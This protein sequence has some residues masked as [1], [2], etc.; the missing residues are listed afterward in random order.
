MEMMD[1]QA[2]SRR[3]THKDGHPQY[4]ALGVH[5]VLR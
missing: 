1:I 3:T 5:R 2:S 4:H